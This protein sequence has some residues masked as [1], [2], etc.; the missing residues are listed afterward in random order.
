MVRRKLYKNARLLDPTSG[1]DAT[2]A[3]LVKN[4]KIEDSGPD[5]FLD[6]TQED[7]EIEDCAGKCIAPGLIDMRVMTGEPGSGHLETLDSVSRAAAAG[8]VTSIVC[9]PN[10][11]PVIDDMA[12]LEFIERRGAEV[13]LINV[14]SYAAATKGTLGEEMSELGLLHQAGALGFTDGSKAIS[15]AMVMRR[16]LSYAT[17][18]KTMVVQHPEVVELAA[19]GVMSEGLTATRLGLTGI[20]AAAEV[21]LIERDLRLVELTGGRYHVSRVTTL[22]GIEAIRKAKLEGLPVTCDTAPHYFALNEDA[23]TDYRTFAKVS[24]PLRSEEHRWAVLEAIEDGTIDAIASDHTPRDQDSKRLPFTQ[25]A[26]GVVGLETLLCITLESV[27]NG[28]L[29][30][31]NALAALTCNPAKILGLEAGDLSPG[32]PADLV[33]F[34]PD[35]AGRIDAASFFSKCKNSPFDGRPIQGRVLKTIRGG[36]TVYDSN[37]IEKA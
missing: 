33:I 28:A 16:L 18:F 26:Y 4:G 25:A 11:E 21:I 24:P 22:A 8:G 6:T 1:L 14:K 35:V 3:L 5:V 20:P 9:L 37:P 23:V 36:K 27:H 13:G 12:L 32:R 19:D 31:L 29:S 7:I 34:D 17:V 15:N 2:G 30:L 10:T